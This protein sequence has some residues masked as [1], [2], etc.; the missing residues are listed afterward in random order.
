MLRKA[1]I[2]RVLVNDSITIWVFKV[3]KLIVGCL[4]H[5]VLLR[6]ER[7]ERLLLEVNDS[8]FRLYVEDVT[9][10]ERELRFY[11]LVDEHDLVQIYLSKR[12]RQALSCAGSLEAKSA[13][14][15]DHE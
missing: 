9:S 2:H 15:V 6:K 10:C 13:I 12:P 14:L 7:K 11:L 4:V 8:S 3:Y 1:L 5:D